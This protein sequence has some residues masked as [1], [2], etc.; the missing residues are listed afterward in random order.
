[1]VYCVLLALKRTFP[2]IFPKVDTVLK[3]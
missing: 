2:E 3:H 1:V